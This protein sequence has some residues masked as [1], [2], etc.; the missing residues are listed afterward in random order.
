MSE[1]VVFHESAL[2][3]ILKSF[4]KDIDEDGYIVEDTEDR[5]RVKTPDGEEI[6]AEELGAIKNG[7]EMYLDE[8]FD[9]FARYLNE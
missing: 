2:E 1:E 6:L 5:R 3:D 7:S 4:D 8:N 9:T